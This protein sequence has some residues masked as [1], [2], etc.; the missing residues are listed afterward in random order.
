VLETI[1][2]YRRRTSHGSTLSHIV[3]AAILDHLDRESSWEHFLAAL[4]SDVA[5]SQGGTTPEG[6][7]TAVMAGTVRHVIERFAGLS[8]RNG[9]ISIA[10]HLPGCVRSL[11]FRLV[12]PRA[13]L[14][15]HLVGSDVRV[16]RLGGARDAVTLDIGGAAHCLEGG[17]ELVVTSG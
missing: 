5:D 15:I 9:V 2:Y 3:F 16:R 14:Q 11:A 6:I 1:E 7:H 12:M 4:R 17:D 8:I 13:S 10:P